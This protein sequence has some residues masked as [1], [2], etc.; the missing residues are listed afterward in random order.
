MQHQLLF[1]STSSVAA[2]AGGRGAKVGFTPVTIAEGTG[3]WPSIARE[4]DW[5]VLISM[6][7]T[8]RARWPKI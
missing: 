3:P 1:F 6:G 2:L 5:D 7:G 8:T 4:Y